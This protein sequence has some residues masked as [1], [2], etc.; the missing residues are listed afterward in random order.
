MLR[1]LIRKRDETPTSTAETPQAIQ[2]NNKRQPTLVDETQQ[3]QEVID[4]LYTFKLVMKTDK[5]KHCSR[6]KSMMM[7]WR[8]DEQLKHYSRPYK[9]MMKRR[10]NSIATERHDK[11][12][13]RWSQ[14]QMELHCLILIPQSLNLMDFEFG[15]VHKNINWLSHFINILVN[16]IIC[17][18][19]YYT[20]GNVSFYKNLIIV[21]IM[22]VRLTVSHSV[23]SC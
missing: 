10:P 13:S 23:S 9:S 7:S 12:K 18:T 17:I 22:R 1:Y 16:T 14:T 4:I 3:H 6:Y 20:E 11:K 15:S 2:G 8:D 5:L 21:L 19:I